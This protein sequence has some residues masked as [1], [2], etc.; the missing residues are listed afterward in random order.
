MVLF[1]GIDLGHACSLLPSQRSTCH[2]FEMYLWCLKYCLMLRVVALPF[3]KLITPPS[4]C[5]IYI[6]NT[7]KAYSTTSGGNDSSIALTG[8]HQLF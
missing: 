2:D 7:L 5:T 3:L 6:Q 8:C 4:S 1:Q